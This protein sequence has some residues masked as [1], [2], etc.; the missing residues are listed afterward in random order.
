M[1]FLTREQASAWI[2]VWRPVEVL[3]PARPP[4]EAISDPSTYHTHI[5]EGTCP[6]HTMLRHCVSWLTVDRASI[7]VWIDDYGVSE[8]KEDW[9]LYYRWRRSMGDHGVMAE[10]PGH[11]FMAHEGVDTISLLL[12]ARVFE[13]GFRA[14]SRDWSRGVSVDNDGHVIVVAAHESALAEAPTDWG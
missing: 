1:Q 8:S 3:F 4:A 14:V 9:N 13:W 6:V 7:L 12:M 2:S 10:T 5:P 11:L